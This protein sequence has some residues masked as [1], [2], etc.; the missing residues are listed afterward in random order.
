MTPHL[1]LASRRLTSPHS[2]F[3]AAAEAGTTSATSETSESSESS[4][5]SEKSEKSSQKETKTAAETKSKADAKSKALTNTNSAKNVRAHDSRAP[6]HPST[7]APYPP[8]HRSQPPHPSSL[9]PSQ[10]SRSTARLSQN[11]KATW[12]FTSA[13]TS[14]ITGLVIEVVNNYTALY[15][16][17]GLDYPWLGSGVI[18]EPSRQHLFTARG[19]AVE[20][21]ESSIADTES[22]FYGYTCYVYWS[23][24]D[25]EGDALE[26]MEGGSSVPV[27]HKT[28]FEGAQQYTVSVDLHVVPPSGAGTLL[29][30]KAVTLY[31]R[32]V[33]REVRKYTD[34]DRDKLVST[35]RLLYDLSDAKGQARYGTSYRSME[36][37]VKKHTE[38]AGAVTCD[39]LHEGLG[40]LT[41]HMAFS[42]E[43]EQALQVVDPSLSLPY[44]DYTIDANDA[45][46][47]ELNTGVDSVL[48]WRDSVVFTDEWFGTTS[49]SDELQTMTRGVW[50][51]TPVMKAVNTDGTAAPV[52]NAYGYLRAPWNTNNAPYVARFN[53][54]FEFETDVFPMCSD[55][56]DVLNYDTWLE[57]GQNI[58]NGA[59][60]PIHGMIGGAWKANF[61]GLESAEKSMGATQAKLLVYLA[62]ASYPQFWRDGIISC[63]DSCD[64]ST[65]ISEC[66]C[67]CATVPADDNVA[68]DVAAPLLQESGVFER[69]ARHDTKQRLI[70]RKIDDL[71]GAVSY[72]WVGVDELSQAETTDWFFRIVCEV[73]QTGDMLGSSSPVDPIFWS[74][75]PTVDRLWQWK[76]LS[77]DCSYNYTWPSGTSIYGT[78]SGHDE[79][80]MLPYY[81]L[82]TH[83]TNRVFTNKGIYDFLDP[84]ETTSPYVYDDFNV[85]F[86]CRCRCP[87]HGRRSAPCPCALR[88]DSTRDHRPSNPCACLP[89]LTLL[90][91]QLLHLSVGPL[92]AG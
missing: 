35:M 19:V 85:S 77:A 88:P 48:A 28:K 87:C 40:F 36:Y 29:S 80:D 73:A 43:F 50:A 39:H 53:R 20:D 54:T 92:P 31:S 71:T 24:R 57:F 18:V 45:M 84:V 82:N 69:L 83:D 15:G 3:V 70:E 86:P 67:S 90:R 23:L 60:G 14:N 33:R 26:Y 46:T 8:T 59:H 6:S 17:A 25:R 63:P 61:S 44:W 58:A 72:S 38:L 2:S 22:D 65:P 52:Q 13:E 12:N 79:Y 51:Y 74:V 30:S 64:D 5:S 41:N 27:T 47:A 49:P 66:Q 1:H 21:C 68:T 55:Y 7:R 91:Y 75:H 78:C 32:F 11:N 81:G 56:I 4:E 34:D 42:L 10:P 37:F 76:R 16:P 89:L 62:V 9:P